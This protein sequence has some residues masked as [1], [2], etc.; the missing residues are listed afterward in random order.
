MANVT[1]KTK[2][3]NVIKTNATAMAVSLHLSPLYLSYPL[4]SEKYVC[5]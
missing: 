5:R 3:N 1:I 4:Y 2:V